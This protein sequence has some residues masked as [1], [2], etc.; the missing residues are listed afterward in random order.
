MHISDGVATPGASFARMLLTAPDV[1]PRTGDRDPTID[2][3][4]AR[5]ARQRPVRRGPIAPSSPPTLDEDPR[6]TW[7]LVLGIASSASLLMLAIGIL[8]MVGLLA[9]VLLA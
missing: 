9:L 7:M 2:R 8:S 5:I 1:T 4:G 3:A 6:P